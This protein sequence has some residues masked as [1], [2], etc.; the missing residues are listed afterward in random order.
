MLISKHIEDGK[1]LGVVAYDSDGHVF[2]TFADHVDYLVHVLHQ[3]PSSIEMASSHLSRYFS[4]LEKLGERW[5]HADDNILTRFRDYE[6]EYI[7]SRK[8]SRGTLS[9]R[10]TVNQRLRYV[11]QFYFWAQELEHLVTDVIGQAKPIDSSLAGLSDK[12][13]RYRRSRL[14]RTCYPI[15]YVTIGTASRYRPSVYAATHSDVVELSGKFISEGTVKGQRDLLILD[16]ADDT[17]MRAESIVSMQTTDFE[18]RTAEMNLESIPIIPRKQKFGAQHTYDISTELF[19]RI[20]RYIRVDRAELLRQ[21]GRT[22]KQ[23]RKA[24][25]LS[26]TSGLPIATNSVVHIFSKALRALGA[27]KGAGTHSFRR[28]KAEDITDLEVEARRGLGHPVIA[29]EVAFAVARGLGH[30]TL[31]AQAAYVK[32]MHSEFAGESLIGKS[33]LERDNLT[34]RIRELE[35]ENVRL[36]K[37]K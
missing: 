22:E 10:R 8:A 20:Q 32:K 11:Y 35:Q 25:F 7:M 31:G 2:H 34:K 23:A 4:H 21:K 14:D 16:I 36:R 1:L 5:E 3:C 33:R 9:A 15:C 26:A 29:T 17:G 13:S 28:K 27:P 30:S 18:N 12:A 6:F 24:L 37:H 19:L